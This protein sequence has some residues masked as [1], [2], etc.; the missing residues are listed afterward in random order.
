MKRIHIVLFSALFITGLLGCR[1]DTPV[2]KDWDA[3]KRE[4]REWQE[5][6]M[7]R[8]QSETGWLN[9]AGLFW[10]EEGINTFGSD[11]ANRL[12]FPRAFPG[13]C[14]A[15]VLHDGKVTLRVNYGVPITANGKPVSEM[16]L[17]ND[18]QEETTR[19]DYEQFRWF[20]I[21]RGDRFAVRLRNR[22]HPRLDELDSIPAFPVKEKWVVPA[23]FK[24]FEEPRTIKVP[25]VIEGF[26]ESYTAPGELHF[27]IEGDSFSLLPFTSGGGYFLI[28]GDA[29]NGIDTYGAGRFLY[30]PDA[31][32]DRILI[33]F[34]KAYNPPCAF[35][36]HATC[37]LPP[38]ENYIDFPV[39]AGEKTVHPG[40][41]H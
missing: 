24:A 7:E 19:L 17:K 23:D 16:R 34:N 5:N 27:T 37:P 30:I 9:L 18:Q 3:Y 10:L 31:K 32:R 25:T 22:E 14:G 11:S 28:F 35:S 38:A 8:L 39:T 20:I 6:R 40:I 1:Q 4:H 26:T 13:D 41:P 36:P 2:I 29:T 21:R 15:L 12:V 33:D